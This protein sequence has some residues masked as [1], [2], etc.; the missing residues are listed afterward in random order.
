M[1]FATPE[2]PVLGLTLD[3]DSRAMA[4]TLVAYESVARP[5]RTSSR[6]LT[7]GL[8]VAG[9]DESVVGAAVCLVQLLDDPVALQVLADSRPR[10]F[11][12]FK[13]QRLSSGDRL[14]DNLAQP[15]SVDDLARRSGM[16]RAVFHRR[17]KV[18]ASL[19]PLRLTKALRLS[20]AAMQIVNG[21]PISQAADVVG[22]RS[23]GRQCLAAQ[24]RGPPTVRKVAETKGK[25]ATD[26]QW[27]GRVG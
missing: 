8:I 16:S 19:S 5:D 6:E 2:E 18:A 7:Q 25:D 20:H 23:P 10:S 21:G 17:F 9:V 14:R 12:L 11:L 1:L 13:Q 27:A 15:L 26:V 4:E 24:S 22:Y 3:L